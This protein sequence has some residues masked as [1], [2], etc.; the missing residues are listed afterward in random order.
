[1]K[2]PPIDAVREQ[3]FRLEGTGVHFSLARRVTACRPAGYIPLATF[4][5][6]TGR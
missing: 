2:R 3:P 1:M 5:I 6:S 4:S